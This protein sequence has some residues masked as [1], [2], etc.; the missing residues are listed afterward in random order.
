MS[1]FKHHFGGKSCE[2]DALTCICSWII[3]LTDNG[4]AASL[5]R[6][7]CTVCLYGSEVSPTWS[8]EKESSC[9]YFFNVC[10]GFCFDS[11]YFITYLC[12]NEENKNT[13]FQLPKKFALHFTIVFFI[14]YIYIC[15]NSESY[16]SWTLSLLL[17]DFFFVYL[18]L[19]MYSWRE[20]WSKL[21]PLCPLHLVSLCCSVPDNCLFFC[22]L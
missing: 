6:M 15:F 12:L 2:T 10:L 7:P 14:I 21:L 17:M 20:H 11:F 9:L 16:T 1:N 8:Y 22:F 18:F 4:M 19:A 13:L 5:L 3:V